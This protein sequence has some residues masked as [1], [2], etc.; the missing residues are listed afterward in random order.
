MQDATTFY[1]SIQL[2]GHAI[3]KT[4]GGGQAVLPQKQNQSRDS[5]KRRTA[6]RAAGT[7]PLKGVGG[8]RTLVVDAKNSTQR[9]PVFVGGSVRVHERLADRVF[10]EWGL[11]GHH[12][13]ATSTRTHSYFTLFKVTFA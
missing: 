6:V 2:N 4:V 8:R 11:L 12:T 13:G 3:L 1:R 7:S 10:E 9:E 5:M